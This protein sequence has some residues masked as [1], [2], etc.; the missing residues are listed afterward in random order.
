MQT[1]IAETTTTRRTP[2]PELRFRVMVRCPST[3]KM[4]IRSDKDPLNVPGG[5][6]T[7]WRCSACKGWHVS[8]EDD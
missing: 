1:I 3:H 7:W 4:A 8:I 6:A 2:P 5:Q